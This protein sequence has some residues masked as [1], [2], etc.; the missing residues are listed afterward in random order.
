MDFVPEALET[1]LIQSRIWR[2][3]ELYVLP[4]LCQRTLHDRGKRSVAAG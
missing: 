4:R 2:N 3:T 1:W